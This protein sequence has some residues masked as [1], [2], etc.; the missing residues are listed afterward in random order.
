MATI[1]VWWKLNGRV[2]GDLFPAYSLWEDVRKYIND[3][4]FGDGNKPGTTR[5]H[6]RPRFR[7]RLT[8]G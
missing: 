3:N 2:D 4:S 7:A 1:R 5:I 6:V 8:V